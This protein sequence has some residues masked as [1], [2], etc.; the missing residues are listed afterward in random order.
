MKGEAL[1]N[2]LGDDE[3]CFHLYFYFYLDIESI[4]IMGL[5]G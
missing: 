1:A 3:R 2:T 5:G 4:M